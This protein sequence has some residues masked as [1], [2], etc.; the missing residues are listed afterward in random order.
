MKWNRKAMA[1]VMVGK[2]VCRGAFQQPPRLGGSC[3]R[4]NG[5]SAAPAGS[6]SRRSACATLRRGYGSSRPVA[7]STIQTDDG[8]HARVVFM[9]AIMTGKVCHLVLL[10]CVWGGGGGSI[11]VLTKLALVRQHGRVDKWL[12]KEGDRFT[13]T[14]PLC[15]VTISQDAVFDNYNDVQVRVCVSALA[16]YS[17]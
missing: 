11:A 16:T 17:L 5:G 12:K 7:L 2:A 6:S 9:P 4:A 14:E 10:L 15:E 3:V 1:T 13:S 8:L